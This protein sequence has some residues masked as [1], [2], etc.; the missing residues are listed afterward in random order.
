MK[1]I[2][3]KVK[4]R[5]NQGRN[6]KREYKKGRRNKDYV[7]F[8]GFSNE[9]NKKYGLLQHEE[10]VIS[11]KPFPLD[12]FLNLEGY[13]F[14]GPISKKIIIPEQFVLE[15]HHTSSFNT[16]THIRRAI[17]EY[18]GEV[19]HIDFSKCKDIDYSCIFLL[20]VVL[21]EYTDH[22]EKI[23]EGLK[24]RKARPD[25]MIAPSKN[26]E[27]NARL[28]AGYLIPEANVTQ[29]FLKPFSSLNFIRGQ[30]SRKSYVENMKGPAATTIRK[31]INENLLQ[32]GF[33]LDELNASY[34][35]GIISEVL[36]NA[37]DHSKFNTWY[38]SGNIFKSGAPEDS[39]EEEVSEVNLAFLNFGYSIYDGFEQN[40][41]QNVETYESMNEMYEEVKKKMTTSLEFS[42]E[43]MFTLYALQ[44][45]VSRLNYTTEDRGTGTMK[46]LKS[47]IN[48]G[49]Y[50]DE[51]RKLEPSFLIYSGNVFLK[52]D[53]K[54]RPSSYDG[55]DVLGLNE[56]NDLSEL[57]SK[58]NLKKLDKSFPGTFLV[59]K[60]Y[61]NKRHLQSKMES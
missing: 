24:I 42:K 12:H 3:K 5:R 57:P 61:L 23:D 25:I 27:V 49:D 53:H 37:E 33:M 29:S 16:I 50:V 48:L 14:V 45:G 52:C 31:Y 17:M 34:L 20:L 47:F 58:S 13:K 18:K 11:S 7:D 4:Y 51:K 22:L 6:E 59:A 19:I 32:H 26:D 54:H 35:D 39:G 21:V 36:N 15:K 8:F 55:I 38:V 1:K 44:E 46:I 9:N 60:I 40:K 2:N 41:N 56:K 10:R 28:M 43:E 30:K